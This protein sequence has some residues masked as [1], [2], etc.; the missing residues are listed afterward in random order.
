[1][2]TIQNLRKDVKTI[3]LNQMAEGKIAPGHRISLPSIAEA[4]EVSA[5]PVR[6]ALSQLVETGIVTYIPNR[7]FFV[8][9]LNTNEAL[10]LY[11]LI[12]MLESAAVKQSSFTKAQ[13]AE[14]KLIN[15]NF[16][17]ASHATER[18][19]LDMAFHKC[20]IKS[21]TNQ[22]A[23]KLIE[24]IRLRIFIYEHVYMTHV[25]HNNSV[26]MH[27]ALIDALEHKDVSKAIKILQE[28]WAISIEHINQNHH[29]Q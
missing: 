8:T 24:D 21:Y 1:M 28:N 29:E 9:E 23:H 20:L 3:L 2:I 6:E 25:P 27:H 26:E 18:L 7:G 22:Y 19:K 13:L 17:K 10:E 11:E 12:T 5:T 4:L 14:L 15:A 16:A